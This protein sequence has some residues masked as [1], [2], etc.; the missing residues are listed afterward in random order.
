[1]SKKTP[2]YNKASKYRCHKV[3]GQLNDKPILEGYYGTFEESLKDV[4]WSVRES[5]QG[6]LNSNEQLTGR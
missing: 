5:I 6:E 2:L 3:I 1:M 4:Q